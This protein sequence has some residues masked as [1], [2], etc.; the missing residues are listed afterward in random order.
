VFA[1]PGGFFGSVRIDGQPAADGTVIEAFIGDVVCGTTATINGRY[2]ITVKAGFGIGNS[3]QEDCARSGPN[4]S[5]VV[6]RSETLTANETGAFI[7][8]GAYELNLTFGQ[9]PTPSTVLPR[10]GFG[11]ASRSRTPYVIAMWILLGAGVIA[12]GAAFALAGDAFTEDAGPLR[13][14]DRHR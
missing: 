7:P 14:L 1:E 5:T 8:G 9:A 13:E 6:F 12:L 2:D 10:T 3:F 11:D 4:T